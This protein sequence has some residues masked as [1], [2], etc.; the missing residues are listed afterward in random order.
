MTIFGIESSEEV[1]RQVQLTKLLHLQVEKN[2]RSRLQ[3]PWFFCRHIAEVQLLFLIQNEA[4][5]GTFVS[6]NEPVTVKPRG[7]VTSSSV[8]WKRNPE[9]S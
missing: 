1:A 7:D 9:K 3:L 5:R 6:G 8:Q 4:E 2:R